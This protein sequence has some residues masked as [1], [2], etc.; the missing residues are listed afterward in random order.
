MRTRGMKEMIFDLRVNPGGLLDQ[1]VKVAD[2]FLEPK[3]E[4]VLDPRPSAAVDPRLLRPGAAALA[5]HA[6]RH[7][8]G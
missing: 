6:D 8:R 7:P 1:G 2:L 3:Q 5:R 4:I